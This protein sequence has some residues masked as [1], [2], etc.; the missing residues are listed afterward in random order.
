MVLN[1]QKNIDLLKIYQNFIKSYDEN[2]DTGYT[3]EV[4][5]GYP[6]KLFNFHKDLPFLL[7]KK[8]IKK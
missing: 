6:K 2:S 1:G 7:E 4:D 3:L 8:K 5:V